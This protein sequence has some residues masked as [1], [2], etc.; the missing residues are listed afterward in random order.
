MITHREYL[1]AGNSI[2]TLES[3]KTGRRFTYKVIKKKG[4]NNFYEVRQL[5]GDDNE[6]S[7]AYYFIGLLIKQDTLK[8]SWKTTSPESHVAKAFDF[9]IKHIDNVPD[10]LR[11]YRSTRCCCCGR[12]LTTP[13]AIKEGI[14]HKCKARFQR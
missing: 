13:E 6:N 9:Y 12:L 7:N 3:G 2:F 8:T 14:G 1:T 10:N 11:V 5:R 4:N